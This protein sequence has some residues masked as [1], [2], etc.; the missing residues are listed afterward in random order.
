[1]AP[2]TARCQLFFKDFFVDGSD[3]LTQSKIC[4]DQRKTAGMKEA[5]REED[6]VPRGSSSAASAIGR[7]L[8]CVDEHGVAA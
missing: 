1:L 4:A 5:G 2:N 7:P 8:H 3:P 6:H